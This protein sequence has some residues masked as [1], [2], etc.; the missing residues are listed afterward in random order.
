MIRLI[1]RSTNVGAAANVGGPV[2]IGF[3]TFDIE[4]PELESYLSINQAYLS[5]E[6]IGVELIEH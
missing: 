3:K 5:R 4:A 1:V 2:D 6:V